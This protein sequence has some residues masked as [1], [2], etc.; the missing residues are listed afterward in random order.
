MKA[1]NEMAVTPIEVAIEMMQIPLKVTNEKMAKIQ[2]KKTY[3]D[4]Y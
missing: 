3:Q 4:G 1:A 2:V